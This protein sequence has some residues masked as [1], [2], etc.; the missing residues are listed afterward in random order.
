MDSF[1]TS[2]L[3]AMSDVNDGSMSKAVGEDERD[4]NRSRFLRSRGISSDDTTLVRLLYE[5]NDYCRFEVVGNER[6]GDGIT[7]PTSHVNDGLFT[8]MAGLALFLPVADCV[9]TVLYDPLHHALG[10]VHLGRHNLEQ[11]AATEAVRFMQAAFESRAEDLKAFL[12]PAAGRA[13][14]PVR[15]LNGRGLQEIALE[16]L[17]TA[18]V[19]E[20]NIVTDPR[21]T[22]NDPTFFSHSEFLKGNRELDGRQAVVA[23]LLP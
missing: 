20:S 7:R 19:I 1:D 5:G 13:A 11:K 23:M 2:V 8:T 10:L 15:S 12:G 4:A 17:K 18:G 9:A 22:T 14:Y 16:Q 6:A 3:V 21:D